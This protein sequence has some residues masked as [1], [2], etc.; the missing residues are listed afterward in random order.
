[1]PA[2]SARVDSASDGMMNGCTVDGCREL[3]LSWMPKIT[4]G[5]FLG[6]PS[7]DVNQRCVFFGTVSIL[8]DLGRQEHFKVCFEIALL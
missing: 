5:F 3:A 1:M 2:R 8:I 6:C 4:G 7:V